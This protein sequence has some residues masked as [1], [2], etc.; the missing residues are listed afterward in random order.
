[1]P[2]VSD[3][4]SLS[5][6]GPWRFQT[7][8]QGQGETQEL[9]K[10]SLTDT[11]QLPGTTDENRK[12]TVNT[13]STTTE[14]NRRFLYEGPAWYQRDLEI[15]KSWEGKRIELFLER[16]RF[17]KVWFDDKPVGGDNS[18]CTPQRILLTAHAEPGSHR[19]TVE[20]DNDTKRY[21]MQFSHV[22]SDRMQTNWNGIVGRIEAIATDPIWLEDVQVHP[23]LDQRLAHVVVTVGN[24]TGAK[25][26]GTVTL[27]MGDRTQQKSV[28]LADGNTRCELTLPM[29]ASDKLWD[30][31]DP[32]MSQVSVNLEAAGEGGTHGTDAMTVDFGWRKF[33]KQGGKFTINDK[34]TF[35]RGKHDGG[36]FP[37]TGYASMKEEDWE[38][39]FRTASSFGINYY[40][41]HS[42]CPPE[43]AF[44]AADK[45]G[46]YLQP[47]LPNWGKF[48]RPGLP[49][50]LRKEGESVLRNYGNH[51]SFVMLTLGNE[52]AGGI[53]QRG[54]LVTH[55]R[56][57]DDRHLYAQGSNN[58][59]TVPAPLPVDDFWTVSATSREGKRVV[60]NIDLA[61]G[62]MLHQYLGHLNNGYPPS[63][64]VDYAKATASCKIPLISHEMG[65][66]LM[67]P[68]F[69]E[70]PKYTGVLRPRPM[71]IFRDRL[72]K[73]GMLDEADKFFQASGKLAAICYK[74]DIESA[75]RT[76][77]LGGFALLDLQDYPGQGSAWVGM[78]NNFM[79]PKAFVQPGWFHQFCAP[80]VPLL[81]IPK[82]TW[83][84]DETFHAHFQVAQYHLETF[85]GVQPV[86]R[87]RDADGKVVAEK[88][89]PKMDLEAGGLRDCGDVSIPLTGLKT[90]QQLKCEVSLEGT[91]YHNSY[92]VW[93]YPAEIKFNIPDK[94][95]V[96]EW[97]DDANLQKLHDGATML[98]LPR[99][100]DLG[101]SLDGQ[102]IANFWTT[103]YF[104]DY[105][106]PGT[107][108]LL[109]DPK[110]PLF[111]YFPTD[112]HSNWEWWPLVKYGRPLI[113]DGFPHDLRPLV[114]VIDNFEMDRKLGLLF[115]ARV[116]KGRLVFTSM[117]MLNNMDKP[118]V[119]QLL[120]SIIRYMD[121]DDFAPKVE[122]NNQQ[123]K[124]LFRPPSDDTQKIQTAQDPGING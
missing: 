106:G 37:L 29:E 26:S 47:E 13:T 40:R 3:A 34:V 49:E 81:R 70:L 7:D 86:V 63:T 115:E 85:H 10:K 71:E 62:S 45:L 87:L 110:H 95:E 35:L 19:I 119:R 100:H 77:N 121:S 80:V 55:L 78:C 122:V 120:F 39:A 61:R 117:D 113:L 9:F 17:T 92:D 42:W 99:M 1:M 67:F 83:K 74:E 118:E 12:G 52:I 111:R 28:D 14:L 57:L 116:G 25:A 30:E 104:K 24:V 68:D 91:P 103:A 20:V 94:L 69:T 93:V 89:L 33:S 51:P 6:A 73:S 75:L 84:D 32:N 90:P 54:E 15:S 18:L 88:S 43:A 82:Y 101:N 21:P 64:M 123:L 23:D 56:E 108:G 98:V 41:F 4:D 72:E 27:K 53:E 22:W 114:Q 107:L 5:L 112:F 105:R 102:F 11:V 46:M 66:Y 109:M 76:P 38:R 97:L 124:G 60:L 58:D 79:E 44:Q 50:Y 59:F 31:F 16:T 2:H 8:P 36:D 48:L 96:V 65:Q